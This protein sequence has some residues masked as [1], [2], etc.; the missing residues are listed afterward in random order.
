[1]SLKAGKVQ[2]KGFGIGVLVTLLGLGAGAYGAASL[3][4]IPANADAQPG[5]L[6]RKFAH[7]ALDAWMEKNS[8]SQENPVAVTDE[9]LLA[10]LKL[11]RN[12]CAGCHGDKDVVSQFG[13]SFYPPTPQ[14]STQKTPG[15]PDAVLFTFAKRGVRLTGMPAFGGML[16]DD[17]IWKTVLFIKHLR[18]L[19]PAVAEQWRKG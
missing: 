10:G 3:G 9:N 5:G 2:W 14:F 1:M 12:N 13:R 6:E 11:Y 19:P 4:W 7:T 8:P 16:N 18:E 17:E 15:D